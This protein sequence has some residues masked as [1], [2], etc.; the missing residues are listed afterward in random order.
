[1]LYWGNVKRVKVGYD[2]SST[3]IIV[4]YNISTNR[5][6]VCCC[7]ILLRNS[8]I[9]PRVYGYGFSYCHCYVFCHIT[10]GIKRS[11]H[12]HTEKTNQKNFSHFIS[13]FCA[14]IV[15]SI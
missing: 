13:Y 11:D 14:S 7:C 15:P 9:F 3:T 12:K 1:M 8:Q 2:V 5:R 4:R 6:K 10:I